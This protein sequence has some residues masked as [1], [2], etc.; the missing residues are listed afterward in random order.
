MKQKLKIIGMLVSMLLVASVAWAYWTTGGTGTGDA[1]TSA[2]YPNDLVVTSSVDN[3]PVDSLHPGGSVP[4]DVTVT[5][6]N[7]G[8]AYFQDVSATI[9][10][11]SQPSCASYFSITTIEDWNSTLAPLTGSDTES[12]TLSMANDEDN[13]QDHCKSLD[14]DITWTVE[15]DND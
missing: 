1:D 6:S 11:P 5:N 14:L 13:S 8:S 7:E 3:D 2:N 10:T 9:L 15:N 12:T 4:I